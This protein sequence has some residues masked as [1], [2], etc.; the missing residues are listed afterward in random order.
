MDGLGCLAVV[1]FALCVVG[2]WLW[3]DLKKEQDNGS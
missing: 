2:Y 1:V 3:E